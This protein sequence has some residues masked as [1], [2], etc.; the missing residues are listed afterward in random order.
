MATDRTER[1]LNLVICLLGAQRPVSRAAL[2]DGIPGY[3]D[4][5]SD[6][7]FER[8]FERDKEELRHMGI[9]VETVINAQGEVEGYR[10]DQD[11]YAMPPLSLD[12]A[13]LNVL[14]VA[15]R[16]WAEAALA[17]QTGAALRKVEA[18]T[19]QRLSPPDLLVARPSM[20]EEHLP[21]LW[22]AIRQ[23]SVISFEYLARG[24]DAVEVRTVD[25]WATVYREGAWYLVGLSRERDAGRAF[26]LSRIVGTIDNLREACPA[27]DPAVLAQTVAT[28]AEPPVQATAKVRVPEVGAARLRA[29]A[30]PAED[31]TWMVDYA[32]EQTLVSLVIESG[33]EVLAPP[34]AA[35]EQREALRR[36]LDLHGD[37]HA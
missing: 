25:P 16:V 30:R 26:R 10:I 28:I 37:A 29:S 15:A 1:L 27:A 24:R 9:P 22:E 32:D 20:G 5:A 18:S 3:G 11:D 21:A 2:R 13:E 8:M 7:A 4:A 36:V 31:G 12:A 34:Q 19:G 14:G 33:G 23:R 6:E 35:G 17:A